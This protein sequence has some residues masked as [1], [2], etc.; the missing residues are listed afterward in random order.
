MGY[1]LMLG[2]VHVVEYITS[3][4]ELN[5]DRFEIVV[6]GLT[7][8]NLYI[9]LKYLPFLFS[10]F[11]TAWPETVDF[12]SLS[13]FLTILSTLFFAASNI[14]FVFRTT[15]EASPLFKHVKIYS[16]FSPVFSK[17]LY[18]GFNISNWILNTFSLP[19]Y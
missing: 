10:F 9:F 11:S 19:M 14:L 15:S 3:V 13:K 1:L 2:H 7:K 18:E 12:H 8:F 4:S 5:C 6:V 17:W 16:A